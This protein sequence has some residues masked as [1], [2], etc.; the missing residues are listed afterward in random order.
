MNMRV[1]IANPTP[2]ELSEY[3]R[4]L[5]YVY[6]LDAFE[7]LEVTRGGSG[8]CS[9]MTTLNLNTGASV[10][11]H[12]IYPHSG[13]VGL[14][15]I[16]C[17]ILALVRCLEKIGIEITFIEPQE[18]RTP[19]VVTKT[20]LSGCNTLKQ[21]VEVLEEANHPALEKVKVFI[22]DKRK[23]GGRPSKKSVVDLVF[24]RSPV[25][26]NT[27]N[28]PQ[29]TPKRTGMEWANVKSM[30]K[31]RFAES[32]YAKIYKSLDEFCTFALDSEVSEQW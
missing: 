32:K 21:I 10:K 19:S 22:E 8:F 15:Q 16:K 31:D 18:E 1:N 9:T 12:A 13:S 14:C 23:S 6:D 7:S 30:W 24:E 4:L 17:D 29:A 20:K 5:D 28:L 2:H 3:N 26:N 11:A 25:T 27:T